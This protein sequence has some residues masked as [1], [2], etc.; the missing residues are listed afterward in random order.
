MQKLKRGGREPKLRNPERA[1][2]SV[3]SRG[4]GSAGSGLTA[5]HAKR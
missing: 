4:D 5:K 1:M 2:E 3:K